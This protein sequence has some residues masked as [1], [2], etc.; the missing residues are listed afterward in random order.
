MKHLSAMNTIQ[1]HLPTEHVNRYGSALS[2]IVLTCL[3]AG[4]LHAGASVLVYEV[5]PS[6]LFQFIASGLFGK[7]ALMGGLLVALWG[8]ILH[9]V[10]SFAWTALYY[11]AYPK[12]K[13]LAR[14]KILAGSIYGVIVWTV[15]NMVV[16]PLSRIAEVPL[17]IT[18]DVVG[19]LIN[20]ISVG[21]PVAILTHRY[22]AAQES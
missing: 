3:F 13:V 17:S 16:T 10:I 18:Q 20:V 2:A 4:M 12:L 6:R 7:E 22:Y 11:I 9:F 1:H 5:R 21:L 15:M 19:I 8:L 14:Y